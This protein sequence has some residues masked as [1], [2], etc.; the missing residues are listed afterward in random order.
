MMEMEIARADEADVREREFERHRKLLFSLAYRMLGSAA[1]AEDIVQE[2]YL[3]W[4]RADLEQVRAPR[5]WLCTAVTRLSIDHLRSARVRR[6]EYVGPW[7]PEPLFAPVDEDPLAAAILAES[8][9]T[10]FLLMLERLSETERAVFLLREVFSF[11][12]EEVARIVARSEPATRQLAKR[13]RDKLAGG[14]PRFTASAGEAERLAHRFVDACEHGDLDGLMALLTSDAVAMTDGGGKAHAAR[15]PIHGRDRVARF[16]VGLTR[17]WPGWRMRIVQVNGRPGVILRFDMGIV[18]VMSFAIVDG[19]I[20][21][22]FMIAN[23]DKLR[24]IPE[25]V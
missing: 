16:F 10:A 12:Y 17:K 15:R 25:D 4:H 23:P 18:R 24:G 1:D 14:E 5:D 20:D 19:R 8:L 2:T 13:A 21:G 7:L 9:S 6:E 22:V 11:D 3:R